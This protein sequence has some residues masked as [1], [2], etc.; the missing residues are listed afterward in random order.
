LP[1]LPWHANQAVPTDDLFEAVWEGASPKDASGALRTLARRLRR[2]RRALGPQVGA[3]I[4]T[5]APGYLIQV[6]ES[7]L[8]AALFEAVVPGDRGGR[9]HRSLGTGVRGRL[10]GAGAMAWM[11]L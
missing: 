2:L 9:P 6:A 11:L 3:R 5:R 7:E 8:D 4:V 1:A 10:R